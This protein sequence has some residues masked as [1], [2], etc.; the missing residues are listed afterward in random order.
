[1]ANVRITRFIT[2]VAP[3]QYISVMRHRTSNIL[4]TIHEEEKEAYTN[5]IRIASVPSLTATKAKHFFTEV[6]RSLSVFH[7]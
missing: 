5:D 2:E 7:E 1:M 4:E 6:Q 3:A